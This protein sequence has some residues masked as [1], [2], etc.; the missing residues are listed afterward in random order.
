MTRS[1][2]RT[3]LAPFLAIIALIIGLIELYQVLNR[4]K[5]VLDAI[6][7]ISN[8]YNSATTAWTDFTL[9]KANVSYQISQ[10]IFSALPFLG[11]IPDIFWD[12][13]KAIIFIYIGLLILDWIS[14]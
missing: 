7:F 3:I 13:L 2:I 14:R 1:L 6:V 4:I 10:P 9:W 11:M 8:T 12:L 5:M